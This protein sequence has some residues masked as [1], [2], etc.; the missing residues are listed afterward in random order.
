MR[1]F[2]ASD[3]H[4]GVG[5][6]GDAAVR[7]LAGDLR[8]PNAGT[9]DVLILVGDLATDDAAL[10]ACLALFV[11]F[12]GRKFAVA[13]N[14]DIWIEGDASSWIRYRRVMKL[15]RA[16]GFHPLEEEPARMDGVGI[17]GSMGW[18]DY[19]FK[20]EELGIPARAYAAKTFPGRSSPSWNDALYARWGMTD[21]EMTAWQADRL[22]RHLASI[23]D[24][25][26]K[27]VAIHHVPT[28]RLLYHPRW[29]VPTEIRFANAFLGSERFAGIACARGVDL[30]VNGHIH[31]AGSA[32]IG[33]TSFAS[34]GGDY[35]KKQLIIREG[36]QLT[37]RMYTPRGGRPAVPLPFGA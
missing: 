25:R 35:C 11:G 15:F 31:L 29:L 21:A 13:G 12:P 28:K 23:A 7:T 34:I 20:D 2:F 30:V 14:H 37:R 8:P 4:Y 33:G 6:E 27:I 19:S 32:R 22:D 9:D 36:G 16:A 10:R 26:E 24:C 18:Y 5:Q 3:L 17:A 1:M